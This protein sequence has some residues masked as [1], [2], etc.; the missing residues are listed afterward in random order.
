MPNNN[1]VASGVGTNTAVFHTIG[2]VGS[3][4]QFNLGDDS[5]IFLEI[6]EQYFQANGISDN[7]KQAS[8]LLTS[9]HSSIYKIIRSICDP[10]LPSQKTFSDLCLILKNQFTPH[11][12]IF[13]K[14]IH[15]Y[16]I[17]QEETENVNEW[18]VRVKEAA[19]DC[20][21]GAH[22]NDFVKDR[23]VSGMKSGAVLDRLCEEDVSITLDKLVKLALSKESCYKSSSSVPVLYSNQRASGHQNSVKSKTVHDAEVQ[24]K[25]LCFTCGGDRHNFSKCKLK[26]LYV[27]TVRGEVTLL[28]YVRLK[29]VMKLVELPVLLH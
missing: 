23:F 2:S 24:K 25:E 8:V 4:P 10:D 7:K 29:S 11:V 27:I 9:V 18:F 15:F 14:R 6:L 17:N 5:A 28:R 13:R 21:F 12:P 1:Q 3:P 26:T 22:L 19:L 20:K 16:S